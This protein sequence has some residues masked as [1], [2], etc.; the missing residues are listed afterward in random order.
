MRYFSFIFLLFPGLVSAQAVL[1]GHITDKTNRDPL[2]GVTVYLPALQKGAQTDT[3]GQYRIPDVPTGSHK[4]EVR[5]IG[6]KLQTRNVRFIAGET[7]VDFAIEPEA[8]QL[9]EV[10]VTGLT[11]G[12]TVKDSPIPIMTYNKIQ[13][14]Q[15]SSTNLV[16]AVGKLPGMSQ[17][18]TGVGLSKPVIRGLGFNRVITVHDGVRQEDNQWGEE[19]ALQI[20]EYSIDRY[21][22]IKGS[23]SLLYGSDGLGGVMSLI[24]SRPPEAGIF[25][26][27]LLTNYQSNN[28]LIGL[29]GVL[30]GTTRS[31]LFGRVRVSHKN[32][33][34]Y[35]NRYDGRVYGSAYR[36]SDVNGTIGITR[37]WGYSQ[38]YFSNW[39]QDINIVTGERDPS[40]RFLQLVR[41][42]ADSEALQP[43]SEAM[44][45]IRTIDPA[46]YQNLNNFKTSWNTFTKLGSGNLS[47]ILSYSQNRRQ[48]FASTL[49]PGQP[50][51][52]FYLQNVFYDLKYY[53]GGQK[54]WDFT[55]GGNG[56]WQFNQNKGLQI[57]YP[58]Y[59]SWDNGLFVFAQKKTDRLTVNGGL[60]MDIRQMRIN[61]LYADS[62]GNFSETPGINNKLRFAGLNKTY[63]NPTGSIG[64][65]YALS[66]RWTVKANLGRGFRAPSTP[67][68][69]ANGEHAGTFRYEI[70]SPN[71]RSETSWQSDLGV[72][73]ESPGVSIT[74]SLFQNRIS[75]FTY[76]EK[77][78]DRF[79]R[80]SIVD[81][82]RPILTYRYVQGNAVLY[83]GE[84]QV[85]INPRSARWFHLT[86]SYSLVRSRNLTAT[87]D[88]ARYL[89]FLPP[90]RLIGQV[91][92]T[93]DG[94]GNR[95]RNLYALLEIEH[96]WRQDQALLAY[97]TE[98]RTPAYTLVNLGAGS[99]LLNSSG[100]TLFQ[101]YLTVQNL[102]DVAYQSHQ[103]RLKYFGINEA[104]GR[105]G[106][107]NM[108]RNISVKL[109]VPFGGKKQ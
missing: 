49:T 33:G 88:S 36:E 28:G 23:G 17:I 51:L 108:G 12:S 47:A 19:H 106:V 76:S 58:G 18:T 52:Y 14:L 91:K 53:F 72:N 80:D 9:Q 44:L 46:N 104:T 77:V 103:N 13:W 101:L 37:K 42:A 81:P 107:F 100:R 95:W 8:A 26:G 34:N 7:T 30:E 11:T 109:V 25:R 61:Q 89:P 84:A 21:E 60:R 97:G 57:L 68:L 96:N 99:D 74:A 20:D 98:T 4:V 35:R 39:H 94:A 82:T 38:I 5:Y 90:P 67:E 27:Q 73:Y 69:S 75:N 54:G 29:S 50:A 59:H 78:L 64:A 83:G 3:L 32:A 43:V 48:E 63:S 24:S 55:V 87:S 92:F 71:L 62:E 10:V 6:Y 31:G 45:H 16:D 22:I 15:T 79:G 102:F 86:S 40:G 93:K 41:V 1:R 2:I 66:G 65:T 105:L 56:L 70:G 85:T